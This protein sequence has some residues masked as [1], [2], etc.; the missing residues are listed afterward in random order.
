MGFNLI[1]RCFKSYRKRLRLFFRIKYLCLWRFFWCSCSVLVKKKN[2]RE[3]F[4]SIF[5]RTPF[6]WQ[7]SGKQ[8]NRK[9]VSRNVF[10]FICTHNLKI[11]FWDMSLQDGGRTNWAPGPV[12][13]NSTHQNS[14]FGWGF[15]F[16]VY[17]PVLPLYHTTHAKEGAVVTELGWL[18]TQSSDTTHTHTHKAEHWASKGESGENCIYF[19]SKFVNVW[20]YC[21]PTAVTVKRAD[22]NK[23]VA[24]DVTQI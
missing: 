23:L 11:T 8:N 6:K 17:M 14:P 12:L 13:G 3:S 21:N 24:A 5:V 9:I 19:S 10:F 7:R 20:F 16:T 1:L 4:D 15:L 22:S 18:N 2:R